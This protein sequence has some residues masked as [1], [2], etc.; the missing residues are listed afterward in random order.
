MARITKV[1]ACEPALPPLLIIN[2]TKRAKTTAR[3]ISVSNCP[4]AVAVS[5]SPRNKAASQPARLR[6][7]RGR[8]TWKIGARPND[9][10]AAKFLDVLGRLFL[11]HVDDI[12]DADDTFDASHGVDA[13]HESVSHNLGRRTKRRGEARWSPH[14][15]L[16]V[17]D[18]RRARAALVVFALVVAAAIFVVRS[19]GLRGAADGIETGP[20]TATPPPADRAAPGLAATPLRAGARSGVDRRHPREA[21]ADPAD[22]V[23]TVEKDEKVLGDATLDG[24]VVDESGRPV[25]GAHVE[26]ATLLG[27]APTIE[28]WE[29]KGRRSA[30]TGADGRFVVTGLAAGDTLLSAEGPGSAGDMSRMLEDV[31]LNAPA[32]NL[33]LVL[34]RL[35][36]ARLRV[37]RPDGTAFV[38]SAEWVS[39]GSLVRHRESGARVETKDGVFQQYGLEDGDY[40]FRATVKGFA[41]IR[42]PFHARL[43]AVVDLGDVVLDPGVTL[44]GRV[45]DAAG[46]PVERAQVIADSVPIVASDGLG[47]FALEHVPRGPADLIVEADG[48]LWGHM[49]LDATEFEG[50]VAVTLLRGGV[51]YGILRDS[52]TNPA[53]SVALRALP[54][55]AGGG[56]GE[57]DPIHI[58]TQD[59]GYM[60]WR[61]PAGR[62]RILW[63]R[64]ATDREKTEDVALAEWV[65]VEGERKM[66]DLTLPAR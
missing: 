34:V 14:P 52:V 4:I 6:I 55:D 59:S 21:E 2:G 5:I 38:G 10:H 11:N 43:G 37:L 26:A 27:T 25:E 57:A 19:G 47:T 62:W 35:G 39:N 29:V 58:Q 41:P 17:M 7:I 51:V 48:F 66:V 60:F 32:G 15:N 28:D 8:D 13:G 18:R 53:G 46:V 49:H 20:G 42:R 12:V 44:R 22:A 24:G 3:A 65:L 54:L 30:R 33:R 40:A 1:V 50:A 63:Q 9:S 45:T 31:R 16:D 36:S 61:L 56:P 64:P 23:A